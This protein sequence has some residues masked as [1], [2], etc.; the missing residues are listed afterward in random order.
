MEISFN[1]PWMIS[2][3]FITCYWSSRKTNLLKL[4]WKNSS[5]TM[6]KILGKSKRPSL[7]SNGTINGEKFTFLP[8]CLLISCKCAQTLRIPYFKCMEA[9]CSQ[10]TKIKWTPFSLKWHLLNPQQ[11][12][13]KTSSINPP[14]LTWATITTTMVDV[15]MANVK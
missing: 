9:R 4:F 13:K 1:S 5:V 8:S 10:I 6:I 14:L 11:R 2:R 7:H 12:S 3:S 15:L